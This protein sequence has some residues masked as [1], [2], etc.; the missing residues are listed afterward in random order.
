MK[1][2]KLRKAV[3]SFL[4]M[5]MCFSFLSVASAETVSNVAN[6][7]SYHSLRTFGAGLYDSVANKTFIAYSGPEMDV[8]VK[9]YNH[10]TNA[11]ETGIKIYDWN[12]SSQ[13]AY[14][15]YPTMVL[16]PDGKLAIFIFDH[17]TAAYMIKAPNAHS[18]SGTWTRTQI[19]SDLN[20]YPM[21]I[22]SASTVYLFYS[23]N[24]DVAY[25]YRTYRYIKSTDN[26]NTWSAPIT[27]IDSGKTSDKY[28]EVYAH[29]VYEKNGKIYIS[30]QLS[31][32]PEGHNKA[33]KDLY[34]A[35]LDTS[36]GTMH[37]VNGTSMGNVVNA[38][39]MASCR[40]VSAMPISS[41]KFPISISQP[42]IADNGTVVIGFGRR[43]DNGTNKIEFGKFVNG[44]WSFSTVTTGTTSFKD[45]VKSGPDDFEVLYVNG[46]NI[47]NRITTNM[48]STWS[49]LY[50]LG[51]PY[52][53]NADSV[54]YANFIENRNTIRVVAG[55]INIAERQRD[56]TGKWGIF[57]IKQ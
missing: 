31:G 32:G 42:S 55:T 19:S 25:P 14:H 8:Y 21:P 40:V 46:N 38:G 37:N 13:W 24:D 54:V 23:R 57:A 34:L 20:A 52:I 9:S 17:T 6:N 51:I 16:L 15:D 2:K 18:I 30:W 5:L 7:A 49:T 48:G 29:G 12:D 28:N 47:E 44:A 56:Y 33:S 41:N 26:G 45:M 11:W 1:K 50:T 39:D 4:V 53:S 43:Y 10:S 27:V 35:Y 36:T 3:L 22:V